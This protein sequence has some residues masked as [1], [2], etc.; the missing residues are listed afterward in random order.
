LL[1]KK[2]F[3]VKNPN[4]KIV[5]GNRIYDV[6]DICGKTVY[7][8]KFL[9]GSLHICDVQDTSETIAAR[10]QAR[11]EKLMTHKETVSDKPTEG[12]DFQ[13]I[14]QVPNAPELIKVLMFLMDKTPKKCI[15]YQPKE[16]YSF[17]ETL[18]H[19]GIEL[20]LEVPIQKDPT[21]NVVADANGIFAI[22]EN[23]PIKVCFKRV[24]PPAPPEQNPN[25]VSGVVQ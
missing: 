23:L 6:C 22:M 12:R 9:I 14:T 20:R 2:G 5:I 10:I 8:N 16:L 19:D 17:L 11:K 13:Y 4:K 3:M 25:I 21:G 24:P 15:W 1:L 18:L 7:L